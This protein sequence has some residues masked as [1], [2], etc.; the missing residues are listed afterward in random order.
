MQTDYDIHTPVGMI[1]QPTGVTVRAGDGGVLDIMS[2]MDSELERFVL[3]EI[4]GE[5]GVTTKGIGVTVSG[6]IVTLRGSVSS[7]ADKRAAIAAAERVTG[8]R[9][10]ACEIEITLP[11]A[12]RTEDQSLA[13]IA[14]AALEWDSFLPWRAVVVAVEDGW[15]TLSGTVAYAYQRASAGRSISYVPGVRGISNEIVVL[16]EV[17]KAS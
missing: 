5:P 12:Y 16:S 11:S 10:V 15:V 2:P 14:A 9:A 17:A 13:Q 8:V 1:G 3:D 6:G 4:I 7:L